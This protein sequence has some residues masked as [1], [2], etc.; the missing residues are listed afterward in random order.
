MVQKIIE[1]RRAIF[2][3]RKKREGERE[4]KRK[5]KTFLSTSSSNMSCVGLLLLDNL[6]LNPLVFT[7]TWNTCLVLRT[8]NFFFPEIVQKP[9]PGNDLNQLSLSFPA[10]SLFFSLSLSVPLS[11]QIK[12]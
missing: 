6:L 9:V 7:H 10:F 11:R 4:R 5:K 1:L 2:G 8:N 12:H 3:E